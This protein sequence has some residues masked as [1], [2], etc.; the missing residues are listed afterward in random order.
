MLTRQT[1]H[2]AAASA[3]PQLQRAVIRPGEK[4]LRG[5]AARPYIATTP[6]QQRFFW[7]CRSMH[8]VGTVARNLPPCRRLPREI[9]HEHACPIR[10]APL[11]QA[12]PS[13][14]RDRPPA[15]RKTSRPIQAVST[16][17]PERKVAVRRAA[18]FLSDPPLL[19]QLFGTQA[20][21]SLER[22]VD[23][24]ICRQKF[25]RIISFKRG[26]TLGPDDR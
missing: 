4:A 1:L 22:L 10:V 9:S 11:P 2:R 26:D 17:A 23:P 3:C 25:H 24:R 6:G 21:V 18:H 14:R 13:A 7:H 12:R 5:N 16:G 8:R 19:Q 15:R 20:V